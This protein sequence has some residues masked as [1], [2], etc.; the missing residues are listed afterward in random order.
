[1][2]SLKFLPFAGTALK[3]LF[4]KPVTTSYPFAPAQYP[5]RMRGHIEI[6]IENCIS[7]GIC[8]R[9]CPPGALTVDRAA[10]T[11]TIQRFDCVQCGNCVNVCPKK[12][13]KMAPGYTTPDTTRRS[14]TFTRTTPLPKPAPRPA[15]K[16]AAPKPAAAGAAAPAAPAK[17]AAAPAPAAPAAPEAKPEANPKA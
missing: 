17:P 1:M 7:C 13:L 9:S 5:E 6:D 14:D 10:G 16:P 2:A 11:W 3:N 4:S 8:A 12:C 15:A